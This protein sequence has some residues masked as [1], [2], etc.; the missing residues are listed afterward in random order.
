[1]SNT[2]VSNDEDL[3]SIAT[4]PDPA[5][6]NLARSAL[7]SE[8]IAVFLQGEN[9]NSLIPMAFETQLLVRSS[10]AVAARELLAS[11][12]LTPETLADVT[13]AEIEDEETR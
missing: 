1:M 7:E 6:G 11:F 5:T 10:D 4:F 13:A 3:V 2:H 9:A 8:G 12:A